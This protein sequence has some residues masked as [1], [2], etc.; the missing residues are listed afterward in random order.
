MHDRLLEF[1]RRSLGK[2]YEATSNK[3]TPRAVQQFVRSLVGH[4][5]VV[6]F[7]ENGQ[8]LLRILAA[9]QLSK[10]DKKDLLQDGRELIRRARERNRGVPAHTLEKE[11]R[12]AVNNVR[13]NSR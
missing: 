10:S 5:E 9:P 11:V 4:P 1:N 12:Q 2:K 13:R 6:E 8:V 3:K 7:E